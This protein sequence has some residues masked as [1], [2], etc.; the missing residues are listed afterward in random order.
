MNSYLDSIEELFTPKKEREFTDR[1]EI[2]GL[3]NDALIKLNDG[4]EKYHIFS[5]HGIGGIGKTRLVKEFINLFL[6]EK[7]IY[8]SFEIEKRSDV[9]NNL[10]QIR[11]SIPS[12]CPFFDL[13]LL[14]YWEI[15]NVSAI[16]KDFMA[17][18]NN[19]FFS[20]FLELF[21]EI[22]GC[23]SDVIENIANIPSIISPKAIMD[24]V[25]DIYRNYPKMLHNKLVKEIYATSTE[26]LIYRLPA[27]LGI[28]INRLI[29]KGKIE[30]PVFVFD[31]YQESQPY[32]KSEE[33]LFH[34]I[35]AIETGLFIVTSRE[36][37]HWD[38]NNAHLTI[39]NLTCYPED[40][41][42][43]L[44]K[45][46]IYNRPDLIEE[47]IKNTQCIPIYIDL[48]LNIYEREEN[49]VGNILVDKALFCDRHK[50]VQHFVDHLK[51]SW[52]TTILDLATIRIF[53]YE[54]F[55]YLAKQ[56]MIE[57]QPYEYM[58]IIQ[59]NLFNYV[60]KSS[61]S[62]L[63]KL[64]DVFCRD[65]QAGRHVNECYTIFKSYLR[66]ICYRRDYIVQNNHGTTLV[67][68]F[69]NALFLSISLEERLF[70]EIHQQIE[71]E[72]IEQLLDIFFTLMS[73]RIAFISPQYNSIKTINMKKVCQF[74]YAK[75]H[76]KENTLK[77]ISLLEEIGDVSCFGK[78]KTSYEAVLYYAKSLEGN[79]TKLEQWSNKIEKQLDN[80]FKSEWFYNR[81]KIYQADCEM[82]H[83]RFKSANTNL[84]L[85]NNNIIYDEDH[86][87]IFRTIGH[88]QRFNFQL[89][90]AEDT[91]NNLL[92]EY[93]K[94]TVFREYLKTNLAETKC[95]FPCSGYLSQTKKL[96]NKLV[97]PYN[98]KNKGKVLYSLAIANTVKKHYGAAQKNIN[99]CLSINQKDGYK[100]GELFAYMAQAYLDYALT[101]NITDRTNNKIRE[102]FTKNGVYIFFELTLAI[103][104]KDDSKINEIEIEYEWLDYK[105][106]LLVLNRFIA[107]L[108]N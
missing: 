47:I 10:Y 85:I 58:K 97:T 100:S 50:L 48:A 32:S 80:S 11:L 25:N 102:L 34:L 98:V 76:E 37:I 71:V 23:S 38:E 21:S 40:D 6:P 33:W 3:L 36:P 86:Y 61:K 92:K 43:L 90:Q 44:L 88:I 60:F 28:E 95:Y 94:N 78:H 39:H 82:L 12:A 15:T 89:K 69:K 52:Q 41:A 96:L 19:N 29:K 106:T 62:N 77:T 14:R 104:A 46:T 16:N 55:E 70:N 65:V 101:G 7:I 68:L 81:I 22:I 18:F 99:D 108:R 91:Y 1:T 72:V 17:L 51:L 56:R 49:L 8:I 53:N 84:L 4:T 67:A 73:K 31:A 66:Y 45:K 83:G 26:Q 93:H 30:Y 105:Q 74:V 103:I 27:L 20:D 107:Q 42:R 59:S 13:A 54:I 2:M 57:C 35:K 5:I 75:N 64:H 9:I 87:S 63:V 79:Y 24:F